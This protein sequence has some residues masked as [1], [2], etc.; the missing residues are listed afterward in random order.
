MYLATPTISQT[1][2]LLHA[3][4]LVPQFLHQLRYF[5]CC[6]RWTGRPG[7]EIAQLLLLLFIVRGKD[8]LRQGFAVEEVGHEDLM[9]LVLIGIGEDVGALKG[10]GLEAED[11]VDD[12]DGGVCAGW[13][14]D[15]WKYCKMSA[16][17]FGRVG[18]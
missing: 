9:L 16:V 15:I 17:D 8:G 5:L 10:L 1:P 4:I 11:V 7:K 14:R 18:G 6:I 12:E 13:T 2:P 3:C